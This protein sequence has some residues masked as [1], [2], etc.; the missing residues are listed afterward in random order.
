MKANLITLIRI[1]MA[2]VSA[3]LFGRTPLASLMA[4]ALMVIAIS[5]DAVDGWV[6]RR[7]GCASRAGAAFD[8]AGDRIL[9]NVFWI[10]FARLGLISYW[11]PIVIIARGCLTDFIRATA[12]AEGKTAFGD[13]GMMETWWGKLLVGSRASRAI[14]GILKCGAFLL[15]GVWETLSSIPGFP[16]RA[17][18]EILGELA[19]PEMAKATAIVTVMACLVRGIPVFIE[20]ARF[21]KR[22]AIA[23]ERSI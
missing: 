19:I 17:A 23:E 10:T 2:F 15:L 21:F 14:Y 20:G 5:L 3:A 12:F 16:V 22:S 1:S 13:G 11:I 4:T 9:E 7:F 8:I 6:A 18:A